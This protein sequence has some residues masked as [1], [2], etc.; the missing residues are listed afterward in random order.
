MTT[1]INLNRG[2]GAVVDLPAG[3]RATTTSFVVPADARAYVLL[4]Y[5]DVDPGT[6]VATAAVGSVTI[7]RQAEGTSAQGFMVAHVP[8]GA[9][10]VT[11]TWTNAAGSGMYSRFA[12]V[13]PGG[14]AGLGAVLETTAITLAATSRLRAFPSVTPTAE[15]QIVICVAGIHD[16]AGVPSGEVYFDA[17]STTDTGAVY[18]GGGIAQTFDGA[19]SGIAWN[20]W[21]NVPVGVPFA[22]TTNSISAAVAGAF[23]TMLV[24]NVEETEPR[25]LGGGEINWNGAQTGN[26]PLPTVAALNAIGTAPGDILVIYNR[27]YAGRYTTFGNAAWLDGQAGGNGGGVDSEQAIGWHRLG[28]DWETDLAGWI[29]DPVTFSYQTTSPSSYQGWGVIRGAQQ[30]GAYHG[31]PTFTTTFSSS[32]ASIPI[33]VAEGEFAFLC[34][35]GNVTLWRLTSVSADAFDDF[36]ETGPKG[37]IGV[38]PDNTFVG[39][40]PATGINAAWTSST[41]VNLVGIN[42][43]ASALTNSLIPAISAGATVTAVLTSA[44]GA[45]FVAADISGDAV[46]AA[47]LTARTRRG[48]IPRRTL[49]WTHDLNGTRNGAIG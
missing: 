49:I 33:N 1:A 45:Q 28:A 41:A 24:D 42:F 7:E 17:A 26:W 46:V 18:I 35:G 23:S 20:A 48:R 6:F 32:W 25:L 22:P 43:T 31:T 5:V 16:N 19:D 9:G 12:P 37:G 13:L 8:A 34:Q 3:F 36:P 14:A 2:A 38:V 11:V 47:G 10:I 4:C 27:A 30:T 21:R 40:A 39:G 44:L 29:A 15:N